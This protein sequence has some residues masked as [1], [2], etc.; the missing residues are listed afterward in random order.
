M[1]LAGIGRPEPGGLPLFELF[2]ASSVAP[3]FGGARF[4]ARAMALAVAVIAECLLFAASPATANGVTFPIDEGVSGP[5]EYQVGIGP[6]SPLRK[7]LFVAVTL[8]AGSSP[9]IDADVMVTVAADG[10]P[11]EAGPLAAAN[12]LTHLATY[13]LSLDLPELARDRVSFKIEVDSR[14]GPAVIDAEM[15]VPDVVGTFNGDSVSPTTEAPT[16]APAP[17]EATPDPAT[18]PPQSD[19][20]DTSTGRFVY[21]GFAVLAG[22]VGVGFGVWGL[23]RYR[24]RRST[25]PR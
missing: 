18:R 19:Q 20:E 12:S 13:E 23:V 16:A 8:T 5:Y 22:L 10:S 6:F 25:D 21:S 3:D 15:I 4:V 9:V 1:R 14:H 17:N 2:R 24:R 11:N 7:A